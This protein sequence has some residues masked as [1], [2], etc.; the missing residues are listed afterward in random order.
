MN[1]Q[2]LITKAREFKKE[3]ER[4]ISENQGFSMFGF[5]DVVNNLR[6]PI[7]ITVELGENI[8]ISDKLDSCIKA[9]DDY[10]EIIRTNKEIALKEFGEG[11][12]PEFCDNY[13][14]KNYHIDYVKF[15]K[16]KTKQ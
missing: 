10:F 15:L 9:L 6:T 5:C 11:D 1:L 14:G 7:E 16:I 13:K 2:T 3:Y 12:Y 8:K 4:I